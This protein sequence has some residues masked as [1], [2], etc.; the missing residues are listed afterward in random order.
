MDGVAA[1]GQH[2]LG[3]AIQTPA[4]LAMQGG[5]EPRRIERRDLLEK[6]R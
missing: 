4:D 2:A 3:E 1:V 5:F 6:F